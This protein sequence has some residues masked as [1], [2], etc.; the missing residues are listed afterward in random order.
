MNK[1]ILLFFI[2]TFATG[3]IIAQEYVV[4]EEKDHNIVHH[5]LAA[6]FGYTFVPKGEDV[7]NDKE[8]ILAPT[9]A[10]K[11]LYKFSHTWSAELMAD[12]ELIE[13]VIPESDDFLTRKNA[14]I[15][16]AV[17]IYEPIEY[18]GVFAGGGIEIEQHHNFAVLRAGTAYEFQI[19][20][21]WDIT[22]SL[23]FDFKEEYTSWTLMLSAGK[24]F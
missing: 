23:I 5:R 16:A 22:P 18:W 12:L 4:H 10:V 7:M 17:G 11:Y 8:G 19:G 20:H 21:D 24:H 13:Y 6:G 15:I 14:L 1:H 2:F 9:L 3:S